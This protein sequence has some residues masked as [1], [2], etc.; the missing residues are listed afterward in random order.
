MTVG[1]LS[2]AGFIGPSGSAQINIGGVDAPGAFINFM[3][4]YGS[5][6]FPAG[7]D[8]SNL[9]ANGYPNTTLA[10]NIGGSIGMPAGY[11]GN[12]VNWIVKNTGSRTV[13][14]VINANVTKSAS[15]GGA[16]TTGGSNS[17]M[18]VTLTAVGSVTFA[19]NNFVGSNIS[20]YFPSGFANV[21]GT[22]E[23]ALIRTSDE[24]AY[25]AGSYFTPEFIAL[26]RD[27]N[28]KT[29]RPMGWVNVGNANLSNEVQWRYRV[30]TATLGW[31][32]SSF[33]PGVWGGTVGGTDTYTGSAATD[34]PGS[35]T[36]GEVYQATVTNA[37]TSTTP[38]LNIGSRGAKTIANSQGTALSAGSIPASS[39][40]TFVYDALLDKV[41][42]VG[43][44]ITSSIPIEAQVQLAN[45]IRAN[46][47][48]VI[49]AWADDT[50]VSTWATYVRDNLSATLTFYPEYSNE[51]WNFAFPQ[52]QWALQRGLVLGF[53]IG[54]NEALYSYYGL[55]FRQIMASITSIW[56]GHSNLKRVLAFQAFGS[57]SQT[58]TYRLQ[59][60]SLASV[61]NGGT[62][63]ATWTSWTGGANYRNSPDRPIDYADV[64]SY[65][66]YYSGAN[67]NGGTTYTAASA[68]FLQSLA[69][70]YNSGVP[71]QIAT[72]L[73]DLD[74]DIRAGLKSAVLGSQTLLGMSNVIY[75]AWE[76]IAA[77]YT[78]KTVEGYEGGLEA[79][80]PT[81]AQCTT[82]GISI[83][84]SAATASTVLAGLLVAYKNSPYALAIVGDQ[85]TQFLG[86][87]HSRNPS[88]LTITGPNQW[89]LLPGDLFST[90]FQTYNGF[91]AFR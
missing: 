42:Y 73:A 31:S 67:F 6:S 16:A 21:S 79:I 19:F 82:V 40:A 44:G 20:F 49:P 46:L 78:G 33:P 41:L 14:F 84:G 5:Q 61:A 66:S 7:T 4:G 85:F 37:N 18:T 32:N 48:T 15:S 53:S 28:P 87:T 26:L 10:G 45:T 17:V 89:A 60:S 57:P 47:W 63:N 55:R 9:D 65:A 34:T 68:V 56:S 50:Y 74:N 25:D 36:G 58:D 12:G 23:L 80:A 76:T 38:T 72:A 86:Q 27:L 2:F 81:T 39:L 62:G 22:G 35:W 51:V 83:G 54:G 75:P 88:W 52:T 77:G 59:G 90:P 43:S 29:I 91:K 24:A 1:L 64:I 70:N 69:D 30:T 11:A 8:P 3:K 71:A 13:R